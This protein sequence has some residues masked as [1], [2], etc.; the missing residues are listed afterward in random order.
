MYQVSHCTF[1]VADTKVE[2]ACVTAAMCAQTPGDFAKDYGVCIV[3]DAA[4]SRARLKLQSNPRSQTEQHE[5][6]Q[7]QLEMKA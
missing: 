4:R 1:E 6:N 2:I 3:C 7:Y 5:A